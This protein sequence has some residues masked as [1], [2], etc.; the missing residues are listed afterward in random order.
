MNNLV[1]STKK[2]T[3]ILSVAAWLFLSL[4]SETSAQTP[5]YT[6]ERNGQKYGVATIG[7]RKWMTKNLNFET[8]GGSWCYE[9]MTVDAP[10]SCEKYGRLYDWATAMNIDA[11][12]NNTKWDGSDVGHQG[13]CPA[14]WH[15][16][17]VA[18]WDSLM[19]AVRRTYTG[20]LDSNG[21]KL[22]AKNGW[23]SN[24][25]NNCNGTD[26]FGFSALPGGYYN[27]S[28]NNF[29][30][31][32]STGSWWAGTDTTYNKAY[33]Y[34][35]FNAT[36]STRKSNTGDKGIDGR[37]VRCVAY[38]DQYRVTVNSG[39]AGASG[40]GDYKPGAA[41]NLTAG[42]APAGK[43]FVKWT[44]ASNGVFFAD[45]SNP[46][47]AFIMP[48]ND[49][50]V[51]AKFLEPTYAVTVNGEGAG[52]SG[53]GDYEPGVTVS[54]SAGSDP[55][56]K[57]FA[58]WTTQSDSVVFA[59][60]YSVATTFTMPENAA[61][62]T[63]VFAQTYTV[64]VAGKGEN[65]LGGGEYAVGGK[66]IIAPG[67]PPE[68]NKF[69]I[70]TTQSAGVVF[71][72]M[73]G[74]T[75]AF[76][77]PA[78]N[79]KVTAEFDTS[80]LDKR[81]G[82]R[83]RMT[84][85]GGVT[86]MSENLNYDT[87]DG[88]GSWCNGNSADSCKKYGRLYNW[89]TAMA[90]AAASKSN[91]S[92]VRGICP[93][94]WHLPS[95]D[96]WSRLGE[97]VGGWGPTGSWV[98]P[99]IRLKAKSGWN[100][101][102][103]PVAYSVGGNGTDELWFSALPGGR[104]SMYGNSYGDEF[105]QYGQRGFWW[106]TTDTCRSYNCADI[107]YLDY[108]ADYL[109]TGSSNKEEGFSVRCVANG[110]KYIVMWHTNGGTV[111]PI[112][113]AVVH[114]GDIETP[115]S[116]GAK[117]GG[118]IGYEYEGMYLDSAY[119]IPANPPIITAGENLYVKWKAVYREYVFGGWYLD[120]ALTIPAVFPINDVIKNMDLYA[121]WAS[122]YTI[123]F[124]ANGGTVTPPTGA[125]GVNGM[126]PS[127]PTP[128]RKNYAFNGWYTAPTGGTKVGT[129]T[130]FNSDAT[131]FA[132]WRSIDNS[133]TITFDAKT[134]GGAVSPTF[135]YTVEGGKLAFLPTPTRHNGIF[136]GWYT[137]LTGGT[138][139]TTSTV[140]TGDAVIYAR[141]RGYT[142]TFLI[143]WV[144][145][146]DFFYKYN[147]AFYATGVTNPDGKLLSWP[148]P[149]DGCPYWDY[150]NNGSIFR[151]WYTYP[152][153][154]NIG[155][156]VT[157][158]YVFRANVNVY[159]IFRKDFFKYTVTFNA[160]GGIVSPTSATT[161]DDISTANGGKLA[162]LPT[163]T[164]GGYRFD[165]WYTAPNGGIEITINTTYNANTTIYAHW[166]LQSYTI[167]FNPSG[168][169][170]S[171]TS[172]VT[173]SGA[174]GGRLESLPTPER[175]GYT[176]I[177]WYTAET[178]GERVTENTVFTSDATIYA[179]WPLVTYS[180]AY[181]LNGGAV[182]PP[183]PTNYT[184]ETSDITLTNPTRGGYR[185]DGW[186]GSNGDEPQTQVIIP[187]GSSGARTYTANWTAITYLIYFD[188]NWDND[189]PM[190]SIRT[191]AGG[192]LASLPTP[193]REGYA[194]NGWFTE[195]VD[196][197]GERVTTSTVFESDATVYAQWSRICV[198]TFDPN[199]GTVTPAVLNTGVGGKLV[200][201]PTP[202]LSGYVF[203]GWFTAV[204]SIQITTSTIFTE[205]A[206]VYARWSV[207]PQAKSV[208]GGVSYLSF[209]GYAPPTARA[210]VVTF[211]AGANGTL[212]ASV[213]GVPI[214]SGDSVLIGK[215][216]VFTAIPSPG[217]GNVRWTV[218]GAE[219]ID[220]SMYTLMVGISNAAPLDVAVSFDRVSPLKAKVTFRAE[221]NGT[222]TAAVDGV[223]IFS[224]DSAAI[225]KNVVFTAVPGEENGNVRWTV[226]GAEIF[227]TAMY[228]LMVG[229]SNSEPVNVV[230][231]FDIYVEP[232]DPPDT[233]DTPDTSVKPLSG[234]L[235][236]GPSP[237]SSG[238]EVAVFWAGN[239]EIGGTLLVFNILGDKVGSVNVNG[240]GKIGAWNTKGVVNGT[241][242]IKGMLKDKDG[243]KCRVLML[244][245]VVKP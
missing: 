37:S 137:E 187:R 85:I 11:S 95:G 224:G 141:W 62:V 6:D 29:S 124:N 221:N 204:G 219:I 47:T 4:A 82:K 110:D 78:R 160:N 74:D 24:C 30:N 72:W 109:A 226:N 64:E 175:S 184:A 68:G 205:D 222:L 176:F 55:A 44:T 165:G 183:N 40:G 26:E 98:W 199:G 218:N 227:D 107:R 18:E 119:T 225:G 232:P 127:L 172:A 169:T 15:L 94:D 155:T 181:I 31:K 193:A 198:V 195:W 100:D 10:D 12:Y 54:I 133:Y 112:P 148:T 49:V 186:T 242:M 182:T 168:G 123:T 241:Y 71:D 234:I 50:T 147:S 130:V 239:K 34:L 33:N 86:W 197:A 170:V 97:A 57:K 48:G 114:G 59:D 16:P 132:Q 53:G 77:M 174:F 36:T 76:I 125:T 144:S 191:A 93:D 212:A 223:P 66:V 21:A 201:L 67:T 7:D 185:F 20:V 118:L 202:V 75:T 84:T 108:N 215:N 145:E 136:D 83:Y 140:F 143:P 243:F 79:V 14:G 138:R 230:A 5:S 17:S 238:G 178:D 235:T 213:D 203:V 139:V 231:S 61:V 122:V 157:A 237:V 189:L 135:G 99:G 113:T 154:Y 217:Y 209:A 19:A 207:A 58:K 69:K 2:T 60:E 164:R 152:E 228:T 81:D 106:T 115:V 104:R 117:T 120:S 126:L 159:A 101:K 102:D 13:I 233:S 73:Y 45:A 9:N 27:I 240:I 88:T 111:L 245:G 1:H 216:V 150:C 25:L 70:W 194:F 200:A 121:R 214:F 190:E 96:E 162:S 89:N 158:D 43:R 131:I 244:V 80:F 103:D 192:R 156:E 188:V 179:R 236:F 149:P 56:G 153:M 208:S 116:E 28:T 167:T 134:N 151:G 46:A 87:A 196:G 91:P 161:S 38:F 142:I 220:Y 39:G 8:D 51:T 92:N 211:R 210:A 229:I 177:G 129:G 90:G 35:I 166:T 3:A 173:G 128:M 32:G 146:N 180:I 65:P 23:G 52:A 63:A 42:S 22:K 105:Q 41:V 163:P 206:L 171:P